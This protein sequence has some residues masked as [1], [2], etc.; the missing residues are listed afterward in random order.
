MSVPTAL[1][2]PVRE[3]MERN[4]RLL[5]LWWVLRWA[6]L[7]EAIWVVYLIDVRGL[8]L[9]QVLLF[10]AAYSTAVVLAQVPTGIMADRFGRKP[11]L[12]AGSL[13]W[14]AAFTAF[15]LATTFEALLGSYL[16]FALGFSLFSGA[17]DAF[18]FDTLRTLGRGEEFAQR[19]GRLNA[20]S[21]AVT[22]GFTLIGS[23]MVRW[24]P[25]AWP[26][27]ISG[28]MALVAAVSAWPLREPPAVER[29]SSFLQAGASATRRVVRMPQLRW[30]IA[31]VAAAQVGATIVFIT[32]QPIVIEAGAPVWSL[33]G[34]AAAILLSS[35]AGGWSSGMFQRG[36]GLDRT[37]RTL[38]AFTGLAL[39]AGASGALWLFPIFILPAF[40]WNA[41]HPLV[42]DYLSRR[43]PDGERATVLS[44]NQLAAQIGGIVV[45][46]ALGVAVDR[47]GTGVSLAGLG[48]VMLAF[49]L[50]AYALWHRE[51]DLELAGRPAAS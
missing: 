26:I 13:G 28:A 4:L 6:W 25:L 15:G 17:D 21:T 14:A 32:F 47:L 42:A 2:D 24:V 22:A 30:A 31:I 8:T 50:A 40:V 19:A 49:G 5:P 46:L 23:L 29:A 7:G 44:I 18:L 39:F 16:L 12:V 48:V 27:V 38:V 1:H 43:V 9:G 20:A 36:L 10:E 3:G 34:F 11:M 45:T 35:G 41:M 51:G 33:G 37:L